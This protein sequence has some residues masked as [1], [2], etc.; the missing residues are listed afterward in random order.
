MLAPLGGRRIMCFSATASFAAGIGLTGLGLATVW[1]VPEPRQRP[2][3]ALPLLFGLQQLTEGALWLALQ[4]GGEGAQACFTAGYLGFAEVLWPVWAPIAVWLIEP[5]GWRRSAITLCGAAGATIALALLYGL[6]TQFQIAELR[7]G[8]I[9]YG[10]PQYN[11]FRDANLLI[12]SMTLYT[13]ATCLCL[14]LS[15]DRLVR[16]FGVLLSAALAATFYAY[17]EWM[18]SVWCF[19]AAGLSV[20]VALWVERQRDGVVSGLRPLPLT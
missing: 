9:Y 13:A 6:L 20:I 2:F 17:E 11:A 12:P 10:L 18:I 3:A 1:R 7:A 14:M 8:H 16:L 5:D 4:S 15:S 19:F